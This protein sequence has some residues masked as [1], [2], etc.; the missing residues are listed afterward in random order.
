MTSCRRVVRATARIAQITLGLFA[1]GLAALCGPAHADESKGPAAGRV[2]SLN[3]AGMSKWESWYLPRPEDRN[4]R[5]W[6]AAYGEPISAHEDRIRDA[7]LDYLDEQ[8]EEAEDRGEALLVATTEA[9]GSSWAGPCRYL[10]SPYATVDEGK[11]FLAGTTFRSIFQGWKCGSDKDFSGYQGNE[12][13]AD[14][15]YGAV[16]GYHEFRIVVLDEHGEALGCH[17]LGAQMARV[18]FGSGDE[19]WMWVVNTHLSLI[20]E[21]ARRGFEQILDELQARL[22]RSDWY[23]RPIVVVG[24]FNLVRE[25]YDDDYAGTGWQQTQCGQTVHGNDHVVESA[26]LENLFESYGFEHLGD[27]RFFTGRSWEASKK[28]DY[29]VIRNAPAGDWSYGHLDHPIAGPGSD[30]P[31]EYWTDHI[32]YQVIVRHPPIDQI[33]LLSR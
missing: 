3:I 14:E 9:T 27:P 20:P 29:A 30:R 7:Y 19:D 15:R 6:Y 23:E 12:L 21:A 25:G 16:S 31:G 11:T 18:R 13:I 4:P 24:D 17:R 5:A 22:P 26:Q 1:I 10:G 2:M 32:G 8:I 33:W 28:I